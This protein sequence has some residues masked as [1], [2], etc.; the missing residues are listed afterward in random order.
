[1]IQRGKRLKTADHVTGDKPYVSSSAR[2]NG[3][4]NFIGNNKN[5]RRF[6]DCLTIAN[7]GSVGKS[8]YH[9]YE[10][11]ASDHVTALSSSQL[12][13]YHY[14]FLSAQLDKFS[15]KYSFNREI[16]DERIRREKILLPVT[17]DGKPDFKFMEEFTKNKFA[18]VLKRVLEKFSG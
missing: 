14:L 12:N 13:K 17:N 16:N 11:V 5:V 4:D 9:R 8:F 10:F 1:M 2:S 7:S 3:V 6:E 15:E 18:E